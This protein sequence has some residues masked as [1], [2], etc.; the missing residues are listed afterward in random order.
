MNNFLINPT[1]NIINPDQ[2]PVLLAFLTPPHHWLPKQHRAPNTLIITPSCAVCRKDVEAP[3]LVKSKAS[4]KR[5]KR[6][7]LR[8][9]IENSEVA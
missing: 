6:A 2:F 7:K 5:S 8:K 3:E 9:G 4:A 1:I